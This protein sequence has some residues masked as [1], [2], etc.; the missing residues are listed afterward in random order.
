[1][2]CTEKEVEFV[3]NSPSFFLRDGSVNDGYLIQDG[4]HLTRRATNKLASNMKLRIKDCVSGVCRA[5][6]DRHKKV[7]KPTSHG[8]KTDQSNGETAKTTTNSI[9]RHNAYNKRPKYTPQERRHNTETHEQQAVRCFN[10]YESNH[11]STAC[12]WDKPVV[13]FKCGESGHKEKH[14]ENC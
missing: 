2:L 12:K 13:C 4:V 10:C 6:Q 1:M 11:T 7:Q 5:A 8:L 3:D 9:P 14:H